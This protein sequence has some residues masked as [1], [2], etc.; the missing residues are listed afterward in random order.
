MARKYVHHNKKED[1]KSL[2]IYLGSVNDSFD[3]LKQLCNDKSVELLKTIEVNEDNTIDVAFW[4]GG[5]GFRE[6]IGV[7]RFIKDENGNL[8]FRLDFSEST[9]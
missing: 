9:L 1:P 6:L 4:T 7:S 2:S 3:Y 5:G 8:S